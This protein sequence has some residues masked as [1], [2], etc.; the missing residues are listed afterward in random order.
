M[1]FLGLLLELIFIVC[2]PDDIMLDIILRR[3][4]EILSGRERTCGW[5]QAYC[6]NVFPVMDGSWHSLELTFIVRYSP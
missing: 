2:A 4:E 3:L 5:T 6:Q 1:V